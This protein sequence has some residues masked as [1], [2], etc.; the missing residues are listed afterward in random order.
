[1]LN[2]AYKYFLRNLLFLFNPEVA[3]KLIENLLYIFPKNLFKFLFSY[4]FRPETSVVIFNNK[5]PSPIGIAA[6]LDKNFKST[7]NYLSLGFGFSVVG[8]VMINPRVGNPK[9]RLIRD[10]A[11]NELVNSLSF[12]SDGSKAILKRLKNNPTPKERLIISVSGKTEDEIIE[13][14]LLFKD[15]CFAIEINISSPNTSDLKKFV[16]EKS[17]KDILKKSRNVTK[18]PIFIKLPRIEEIGYYNKLIKPIRNFSDT[19]VVL[20][21]TL[22]VSDSRLK[23][24]NGGK[25]GES[26]FK[27]TLKILKYV[28]K[29]Y[30]EIV[31]MCSGG[32]SSPDNAR[33]LLREGAN[34][35]QIY[36][37]LVYQGPG[38]IKELNDGLLND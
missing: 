15:Y 23:V 17:I 10:R 29:S 25:S 30:P 33:I 35:L 22:P 1:M 16:N 27:S 19:G 24:G 3:H 11:K 31:I 8:T 14:I 18:M 4:K 7:P 38:I 12:P 37:S 6:G 32:I 34:A 2:F 5:I 26:L 13:N 28:R 36:T 9:P 21:N 20:S